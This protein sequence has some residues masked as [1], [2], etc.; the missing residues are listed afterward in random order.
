M[1]K[2]LPL[3]IAITTCIATA[4]SPATNST[5]ASS[6]TI[7]D[8]R[9]KNS[10]GTS[11]TRTINNNGAIGV[12]LEKDLGSQSFGSLTDTELENIVSF[13]DAENGFT[14]NYTTPESLRDY[15]LMTRIIYIDNNNNWSTR[16]NIEQSAI[17][18]TDNTGT[19]V[20]S[21]FSW[22]YPLVVPGRTY[23][24]AI[25]FQYSKNGVTN[26]P[27][28]QLYYHI[29]PQHGI[30]IIDDLPRGYNSSDYTNFS[31][32]VFSLQNVIPVESEVPVQKSIGMFGT[33]FYSFV[34]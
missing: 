27:D 30:G 32:G 14:I 22:V 10:S 8:L 20:R 24:F 28:F 15:Q 7:L 34:L 23:K 17:N 4:C 13:S 1:K 18:I 26:P 9:N 3:L 33:G 6:T 31:N 16:Q 5:S 12:F 25:Q 2:I 11:V 29:T 19:H 21:S